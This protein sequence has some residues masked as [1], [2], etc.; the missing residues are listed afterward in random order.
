MHVV[1]IRELRFLI[2]L[3]TIHMIF[4]LSTLVNVSGHLGN[5]YWRSDQKDPEFQKI[6]F[7]NTIEHL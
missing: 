7:G 6:P 5:Y 3:Y 4:I 1:H 2:D